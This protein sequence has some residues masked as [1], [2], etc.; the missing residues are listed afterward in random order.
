MNLMAPRPASGTTKADL[1]FAKAPDG[2]S[3]L[4]R[5]FLPYPFHITRPFYFDRDPA[6]MATVYLQS[7]AGGAY[8]G[9]RLALSV[10]LEEGAAAHVTTQ[11]ST[12]VHAGRGGRTSLAQEIALGSGAF[13]EFLPDPLILMSGADCEVESELRLQEGARL[14]FSDAFLTHDPEEQGR[15]PKA[16]RSTLVVRAPSGRPLLVDR[17]HLGEGAMPL[18]RL[19]DFPCHASIVF[20]AP[21]GDATLAAQLHSVLKPFVGVFAGVS[22]LTLGAGLWVRLLAQDGVS[23]S[24]ALLSVWQELR[25]RVTSQTAEPRRK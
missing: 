25:C 17:F 20:I 9:D 16:F 19:G 11:A 13:L 10:T 22:S 5:Q 14:L 18:S 23:L 12:L 2:R 21:E 15:P 6:G 1:V 8:R 3:Y 4:A 24:A 7:A